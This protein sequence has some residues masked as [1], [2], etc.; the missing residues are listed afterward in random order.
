MAKDVTTIRLDPEELAQAR[1]LAVKEGVDM[2][3]IL[4]RWIRKGRKVDGAE[5]VRRQK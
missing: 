2:A 4:R 5:E 1:A 3:D